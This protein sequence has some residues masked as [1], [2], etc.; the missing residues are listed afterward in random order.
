MSKSGHTEFTPQP[1]FTFILSSSLR[2]CY[3][4]S[5]D[6]LWREIIGKCRHHETTLVKTLRQIFVKTF[7]WRRLFCCRFSKTFLR[8]LLLAELTLSKKNPFVVVAQFQR[9]LSHCKIKNGVNETSY[10]WFT[11]CAIVFKSS[12]RALL[13]NTWIWNILRTYKFMLYLFLSILVG[14]SNLFSQSEWF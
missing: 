5:E 3:R 11:L 13:K 7:F 1:N 6:N 9:K 14:C 4:R 2:L 8:L 12:S 10:C